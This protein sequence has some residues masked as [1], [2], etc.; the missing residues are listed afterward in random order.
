MSDEIHIHETG[1]DSRFAG[2]FLTIDLSAL[3]ANYRAL[4]RTSRPARTAAVV[5]A[6]AYGLGTVPVV[7]A[8][9]KAGCEDFFVALPEEGVAVRQIAPKARIFVLGGL[10]GSEAAPIYG[11]HGMIPV[12]NSLAEIATWEAFCGDE[13]ARH[14]CAIHV[15]TG[16]NRLGLSAADV[17]AFTDDNSLTGAI[18]PI[19]VMSHL[20]CAD[21]RGQPM[22]HRQLGA[23]RGLLPAFGK[24]EASLAN[25]AGIVLG[26]DYHFDLT[27]PGIA[28]Y[29]GS[30]NGRVD[31]EPVVTAS[32]RIV[33]IRL[34]A[35]GEFASYGAGTRLAR[36]TIIAVAGV[37]YADGFHRSASGAGV[38][39][40]GD[41]SPGGHGF[42]NGA[43]VP[44]LGRI[45]MDT[46]LFD[47]TDL[48]EDAVSRG[49]LIELF[50]PNIPID[51][52]S[53]TAGTIA[54]ELL[55]GIGRRYHRS[56]VSREPAS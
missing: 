28:L 51:E 39:M 13:G 34:A 41:G 22:N 5:K 9:V 46:T 14:P 16:M 1:A 42:V 7:K 47:V 20:A 35:A 56:Y 8:L 32:A 25:S 54:Y 52:A 10:F 6:D 15:D 24:V 37:G 45:T 38:V 48:G 33:Q 40:R 26:H 12:L 23:F 31:M 50:G 4:A 27:R 55:T 49:D 17:A 30:P 11:E 2:G 53:A 44:I 43:R 29:G 21:D 3:V 19:L 18:Q 36:D